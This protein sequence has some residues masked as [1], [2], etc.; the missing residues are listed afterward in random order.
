[1]LIELSTLITYTE[2]EI[3]ELEM[4]FSVSNCFTFCFT[5]GILHSLLHPPQLK[6]EVMKSA[7]FV[8]L[9]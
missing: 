4:H 7:L 8:V 3:W 6:V 2:E 9:G 5:W 1:M